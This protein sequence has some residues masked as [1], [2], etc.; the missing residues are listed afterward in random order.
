MPDYLGEIARR[1]WARV[2]ASTPPGMITAADS[3][4]LVAYYEACELVETVSRELA[5]YRDLAGSAGSGANLRAAR[6]N[7]GAALKAASG[8]FDTPS[9]SGEA[10][11]KGADAP[12]D[13]LGASN[14]PGGEG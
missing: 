14:A 6:L 11:A 5:D 12:G 1:T 4:V 2:L 7:S 13:A 9:V 10:A 3:G 8:V